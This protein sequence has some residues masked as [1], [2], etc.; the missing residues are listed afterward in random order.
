MILKFDLNNITRRSLLNSAA[1]VIGS[2]VVA[3]SIGFVGRSGSQ[4]SIPDCDSSKP[5]SS[6]CLL[7]YA[8]RSGMDIEQFEACLNDPEQLTKVNAEKFNSEQEKIFGS[9]T[10]VVGKKTEQ[11]VQGFMIG[12]LHNMSDI[13]QMLAAAL[14]TDL[15]SA[16]KF[17]VQKRLLAVNALR[18]EIEKYFASDQGGGLA[19]DELQNKVDSYL[20]ELRIAAEAESELKTFKIDY[21]NTDGSGELL[22]INFTDYECPYCREFEKSVVQPLKQIYTGSVTFVYKNSPDPTLYP[23]STKAAVAANCASEQGRFADYSAKLFGL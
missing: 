6:D 21:S 18:I 9:P 10:V 8:H 17:W 7:S 11:G 3:L 4:E 22:F 1:L 16:Q 19:G 23:G 20:S 13:D 14:T 15:P 12:S 5:V 2:A